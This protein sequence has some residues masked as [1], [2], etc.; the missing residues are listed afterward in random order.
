MH[1]INI[2]VSEYGVYYSAFYAT[3]FVAGFIYLAR[4][5]NQRGF[6]SLPWWLVIT[7]AFFCFLMGTQI[8]RLGAEEWRLIFRLEAIPVSQGRSTLGGLL[9][10]IP[11]LM[12]ARYLLKFKYRAVDTFAIVIPLGLSIQR[13]G[14]FLAGCCHGTATDLPMSVRYNSGSFAFH[15]QVRHGLIDSSATFALPVHPVQLY[16][17]L[18]CLAILVVLTFLKKKLKAPG[19]LLIASLCL[20]GTC[21]FFLEFI[22]TQNSDWRILSLNPVQ[23]GL[24]VLIPALAIFSYHREKTCVPGRGEKNEACPPLHYGIYL[25]G[26]LLLFWFCSRWMN[27]LEIFSMN[28]ILLPSI[29]FC[30]WKLYKA[31]TPPALRMTNACL[32]AVSILCMSQTFPESRRDSTKYSYNTFS[33]GSLLGSTSYTYGTPNTICGGAPTSTTYASNYQARGVGLGRT[34]GRGANNLS[35]GLNAFTATSHMDVSGKVVNIESWS[36]Y[37]I[38]PYVQFNRQL[39]GIGAGANVGNFTQILP[40]E[41]GS[42]T[43]FKRQTVSPSFNIRVGRLN[44]L[45]LEYRFASQFPT[46]SPALT[47]QFAAGVGF[48]KTFSGIVRV[49][50]A[51]NAA[52]FVAPSFHIGRHFIFEHYLGIGGPIGNNYTQSSAF[53][54][55]FNV[56]YK[57]AKK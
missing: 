57:F 26:F 19:S 36:S 52:F 48:G 31:A 27:A 45:F 55:S 34:T 35:F 46:F 2:D 5:G 8:I 41:D 40:A 44:N 21:R 16:D 23:V 4:A 18:C 25:L 33:L 32:C 30:A 14:C 20:Y 39:F 22:R 28:I 37:G 6:P 13:I 51:S 24:L 43:N 49:G 29:M 12:L 10:G 1:P 3:A 53:V 7:S 54:G 9:F 42:K 56:H 17:L 11:G 38:N 47:Q 15:D 50:T